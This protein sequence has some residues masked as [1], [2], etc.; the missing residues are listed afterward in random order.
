MILASFPYELALRIHHDTLQVRRLDHVQILP[1]AA[2]VRTPRP[3]TLVDRHRVDN[4]LCDI[5]LCDSSA[6]ISIRAFLLN[7]YRSAK[8]VRLIRTRMATTPTIYHNLRF[9]PN[10]RCDPV[11]P[12]HPQE[13]LTLS[14]MLFEAGLSSRPPPKKCIKKHSPNR[15]YNSTRCLTITFKLSRPEHAEGSA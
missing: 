8:T 5:K 6:T 7:A 11:H 1:T 13:A 12:S 2:A 3:E 15:P 14:Q 10:Y 9:G 4:R